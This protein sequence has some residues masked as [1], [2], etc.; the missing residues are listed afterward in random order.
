MK[1]KDRVILSLLEALITEWEIS[2]DVEEVACEQ[3]RVALLIEASET[4]GQPTEK[5]RSYYWKVFLRD[6]WD[7]STSGE[8]KDQ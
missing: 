2:Y 5:I 7:Q 1:N 6:V 3:Q 8:T 4:L